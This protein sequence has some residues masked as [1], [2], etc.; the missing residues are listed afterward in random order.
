MPQRL[1]R[2][3][4]QFH[5]RTWIL[6][7]RRDSGSQ[8]HRWL[9]RS[10]LRISAGMRSPASSSNARSLARSWTNGKSIPRATKT[11]LIDFSAACCASKQRSSKRK[12]ATKVCARNRLACARLNHSSGS[13]GGGGSCGVINDSAFAQSGPI[14]KSQR[15]AVS[16]NVLWR[17]H[18]D[19]NGVVNAP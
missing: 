12:P 4:S 10:A 6:D 11:A 19:I 17:R 8:P 1:R 16:F 9:R 18:D 15:I 5:I 2:A 14:H 13:S 7:R 3:Q